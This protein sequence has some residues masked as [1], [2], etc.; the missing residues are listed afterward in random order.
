MVSLIPFFWVML[1]Y[2]AGN[3]TKPSSQRPLV[4]HLS[5]FLSVFHFF[6]SFL[7]SFCLSSPAA[8]ASQDWTFKQTVQEL[9]LVRVQKAGRSQGRSVGSLII[10]SVCVCIVCVR[11]CVWV[12][13]S[14]SVSLCVCACVYV[15]ASHSVSVSLLVCVCLCVCV[16]ACACVSVSVCICA[17]VRV[18]A[19]VCVRV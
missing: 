17:S 7:L 1:F 9:H 19:R 12:C 11:A 15:C 10:T 4:K 5:F 16:R 13:V 14:V 6:N 3:H 8:C 18:H 2:W